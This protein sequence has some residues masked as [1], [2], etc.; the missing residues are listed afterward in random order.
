MLDVWNYKERDAP[1][2]VPRF[3]YSY[4]MGGGSLI[5]TARDLA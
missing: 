4:N 3:D 1:Q 2:L 5:S